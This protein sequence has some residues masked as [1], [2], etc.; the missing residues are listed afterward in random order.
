MPLLVEERRPPQVKPVFALPW[1][2]REEL[3]GAVPVL[4]VHDEIV[5]ECDSSQAEIASTWLKK[6]M[7]DAMAPLIDPVPMEVEV[8]TGSTWG[9]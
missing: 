9:G 1:E 8:K 5:I 4:A 6:A 3:P 2:R 7:L